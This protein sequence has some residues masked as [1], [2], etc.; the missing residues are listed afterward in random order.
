MEKSENYNFEKNYKVRSSF[1]MLFFKIITLAIILFIISLLIDY[2]ISSGE[3]EISNL[4]FFL[5]FALF[6]FNILL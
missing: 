2:F 3:L 6:V 5:T 4:S 1:Y